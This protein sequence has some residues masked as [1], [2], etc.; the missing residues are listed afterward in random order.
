MG[1]QRVRDGGATNTTTIIFPFTFNFEFKTRMGMTCPSLET[2]KER[3]EIIPVLP[4][5]FSLNS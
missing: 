4:L 1:L 3:M 2:Q 5:L